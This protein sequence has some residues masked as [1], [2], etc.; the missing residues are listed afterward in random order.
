MIFL[1]RA[2]RVLKSIWPSVRGA[3]VS[4]GVPG[5]IAVSGVALTL[6]LILVWVLAS[7]VVGRRGRAYVSE[8]F[9]WSTVTAELETIYDGLLA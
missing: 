4:G 7:R 3:W 2:L 5:R 8:H 6:L 1:T 9:D